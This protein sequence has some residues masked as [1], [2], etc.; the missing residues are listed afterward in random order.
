ML[1]GIISDA[2]GNAIALRK[3]I[4]HL[5]KKVGKVYFLGDSCGYFPDIN[6]CLDVLREHNVNCIMGN[7]DAM[8]LGLLDYDKDKDEIYKLADSRKIISK[9]NLIFLEGLSDS[10]NLIID[11]SR[12]LFVHGGPE[13]KLTEYIYPDSDLKKYRLNNFDW[14]FCGHT[15]RPFIG[16]IGNKTIVNV[17]SCGLPRD[18]GNSFSMAIFDTT[19]KNVKIERLTIPLDEIIEEYSNVHPS[20]IECLKRNN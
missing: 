15:H 11:D 2:H 8:L 5:N 4:A 16:S 19:N 18:I 9:E 20:V 13:N 17:G 3:C 14:L 1:I 10:V 7:H 12:L 6:G